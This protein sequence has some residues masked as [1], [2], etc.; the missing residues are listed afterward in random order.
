[1]TATLSDKKAKTALMLSSESTPFKPVIN[2]RSKD[3]HR[4]KDIVTLLHQD[5]KRREQRKKV[6]QTA[7]IPKSDLVSKKSDV[8]MFEK[9]EHRLTSEFRNIDDAEIG[10]LDYQDF[11]TL[12]SNL[13]FLFTNQ[14]KVAKE[15]PEMLY[16][17]W[18]C[19][20]PQPYETE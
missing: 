13:D 12:L 17:L 1:M 9:F 2:Q 3:M 20:C 11:S 5:A 19:V 16:E 4:S 15:V 6:V 18:E 8:L 7:R 10:I 14:Y